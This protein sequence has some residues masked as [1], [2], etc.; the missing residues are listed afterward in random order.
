MSA[1]YI[2]GDRAYMISSTDFPR[3]C[4][5]QLQV[6]DVSDPH[7]PVTHGSMALPYDELCDPRIRAAGNMV[8]IVGVGPGVQIIDA[9]DP[10]KPILRRTYGSFVGSDL[11]VVG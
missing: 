8:Y 10:D 7:N 3:R 5:I 4:N 2:D 11:R 9:S 6:F 1:I